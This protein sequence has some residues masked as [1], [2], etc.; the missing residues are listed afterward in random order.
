MLTQ[1]GLHSE[2]PFINP[3]QIMDRPHIGQPRTSDY[4]YYPSVIVS[5]S[6][7][8]VENLSLFTKGK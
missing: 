5:V 7:D 6:A 1:D 4:D 3:M 2:S 8:L